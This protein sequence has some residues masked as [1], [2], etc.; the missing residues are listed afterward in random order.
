VPSLSSVRFKKFYL[1]VSKQHETRVLEE[2]ASLNAAQLIDAREVVAGQAENPDLYD[3]FLR[4]GQRC[5]A[6]MNAVSSLRGRFGDLVPLTEYATGEG[7]K[8]QPSLKFQL[9]EIKN[10]LDGYEL[11]LNGLNAEVDRLLGEVETLNAVRSK[12]TVLQVVDVNADSLGTHTFTVARAGLVPDQALQGVEESIASLSGAYESR[13]ATVEQSLMVIVVPRT[14]REKL[15]DVLTRYGFQE[16]DLPPG[17]DP[18]PKVALSAVQE[19]IRQKLKDSAGLESRLRA[20]AD[21]LG[22]RTNYVRFLK[23]ATTVVSRTEALSV[24]QGWIIETAVEDLRRKVAAI[25]SDSYYLQVENP[26]HGEQTPVL[27]PKRGWLL[28]G[29]ELLTSVRGMPSYNE[30][31]PTVIFAILFPIMYGMMFGDVGDGAVILVLGL[32]FYRSKSA[33][34][35]ISARALKSLGTI[36]VVSGISAMVFGFF[37]GSIFLARTPFGPLLF[38]PVTSFGTIVEVALAFGVIQVAISLVL[39]IRNNFARGEWKEAVISGKGVLGMVYYLVGIVLAIRLIQ[40]GL[41]LSLFGAPENFLLTNVALVC[42]LLILLS[43][44]LRHL[45]SEELSVGKDIIE[46]FS[47]LLEV[48]I[49]FLTNSLSYLRLAAFALAHGIFAGFAADLGNSIGLVESLLFV[50]T[51]IILVDG[52]AAGIQSVRLLYYEFSTRFFAAS[53]QRFKPLSLKL[54]ENS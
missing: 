11:T 46:G 31:D 27:L 4:M 25:T 34:I 1:V 45:G 37:Y 52:F 5:S 44:I 51:L 41:Q 53:G 38:E 2:I 35:G 50:N 20:L 9:N 26:K 24:S 36:M 19:R 42:L 47:E 15:D 8:P 18:D 54:T 40:G 16:I 10:S 21:E 3:R 6:L 22:A 32:V 30:L 28:K 13:K 17:L 43:P 33:H 14:N 29:F 12:L 49:S 39:N 7:A 48:F 23:E